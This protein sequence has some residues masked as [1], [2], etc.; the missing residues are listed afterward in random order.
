MKRLVKIYVDLILASLLAAGAF[1]CSGL[2]EESKYSP[3]VNLSETLECNG[4]QVKIPHTVDPN[5]QGVLI[6]FFAE[7][8]QPILEGNIPVDPMHPQSTQDQISCITCH[9]ENNFSTAIGFR[10]AQ[11]K[12]D[13]LDANTQFNYTQFLCAGELNFQ[14]PA[15]SRVLAK[16]RGKEGMDSSSDTLPKLPGLHHMDKN[17]IVDSS[18]GLV[19]QAFKQWTQLE[20]SLRTPG[21]VGL[22]SVAQGGISQLCWI[23]RP[24]S[25]FRPGGDN[26]TGHESPLLM[27]QPID[28]NHKLTGTPV[29]I[30]AMVTPALAP[31]YN[32]N[33]LVSN[34]GEDDVF[35]IYVG[36]SENGQPS[37]VAEIKLTFAE[38][39][40]TSVVNT[41]MNSPILGGEKEFENKITAAE[42]RYIVDPTY[43]TTCKTYR[44][45]ELGEMLGRC[46]NAYPTAYAYGRVFYESNQPDPNPANPEYPDPADPTQPNPN[47]P[48]DVRIS[49]ADEYHGGSIAKNSFSVGDDGIPKIFFGSHWHFQENIDIGANGK[50]AVSGWDNKLHGGRW[51]SKGPANWRYG[52]LTDVEAPVMGLSTPFRQVAQGDLLSKLTFL[53][54]GP[55]AMGVKTGL[56]DM[57]GAVQIAYHERGGFTFDDTGALPADRAQPIQNPIE[58]FMDTGEKCDPTDDD[59]E[60]HFILTGLFGMPTLDPSGA[61][62]FAAGTE[63]TFD[64]CM[65]TNV[66][67]NIGIWW[68]TLNGDK[69]PVLNPLPAKPYFSNGYFVR[70]IVWV[71]KQQ[72][73]LEFMFDEPDDEKVATVHIPNVP[74][75][76]SMKDFSN[77]D[78]QAVVNEFASD[79][80]PYKVTKVALYRVM[81][82]PPS[83]LD[84][85]VVSDCR[86]CGKHPSFTGTEFSTNSQL[87][88]TAPLKS[89]GSVAFKMP[90]RI[91]YTLRFIAEVPTAAG[92]ID[93]AIRQDQLRD[94]R[95][96]FQQFQTPISMIDLN[97]NCLACH[98]SK[99]SVKDTILS[100]NGQTQFDRKNTMAMNEGPTDCY[101]NPTGS[102]G[103]FVHDVKPIFDGKTCKNC[104]GTDPVSFVDR[105]G[106]THHYDDVSPA[107]G[108]SFEDSWAD[109]NDPLVSS[110]YTHSYGQ[111]DKCPVGTKEFPDP[112]HPFVPFCIPCGTTY[113]GNPVTC[114][115]M[116]TKAPF[117]PLYVMLQK[118]STADE[119]MGQ[120]VYLGW[121][122]SRGTGNDRNPSMVGLCGTLLMTT[123]GDVNPFGSCAGTLGWDGQPWV[124]PDDRFPNMVD[125][126]THQPFHHRGQLTLQ[127]AQKIT[128]AINTGWDHN[129]A[130]DEI[131]APAGTPFAGQFRWGLSP[132]P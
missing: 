17:Y 61:A 43:Q 121:F 113:Q 2:G 81:N 48:V 6:Q 31:G 131:L 87:I 59:S 74:L 116:G 123:F 45:N 100:H 35:K 66:P 47:I 55:L 90:S 23:E 60:N 99:N 76:L 3:P 57:G 120:P 38:K 80:S 132:E 24:R 41:I 7:Q 92:T 18:D 130:I 65:P 40:S 68:M 126:V 83:H 21:G 33:R 62:L 98:N 117:D 97:N 93:V 110:R 25:D 94:S 82:N 34:K 89:D 29:D 11:S 22:R 122:S 88:C 8:I 49:G 73:P 53:I 85:S 58:N 54:S 125:P 64:T 19:Y 13:P 28:E 69:Q 101:T 112:A 52:S 118:T 30:T 44:M 4:S 12:L 46:S 56:V 32:L 14:D 77:R 95:P 108:L 102:W 1:G 9:K 79:A 36:I 63:E 127:D 51:M 78:I 20:A 67:Q 71:G 128:E 106:M 115:A 5:T 109:T 96:G 42:R 129:R 111:G 75:Y 26:L 119:N 84:S 124:H 27:C 10:P 16:I 70:D 37:N 91:G 107:G 103:D 105:A 39:A 15:G 86:G 72:L 114:E 50:F 104:H